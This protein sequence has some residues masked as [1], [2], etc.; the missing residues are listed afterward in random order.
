MEFKHGRVVGPGGKEGPSSTE[1][2][3]AGMG[4]NCS[5]PSK[6]DFFSANIDYHSNACLL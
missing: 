2:G 3:E 5:Y 1:V 4:V 6:R